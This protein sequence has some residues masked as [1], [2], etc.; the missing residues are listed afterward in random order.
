MNTFCPFING[1]CR[2]DCVFRIHET[3]ADEE[4]ITVCRL[5]SSC[6]TNSALCD[7]LIRKQDLEN[8]Q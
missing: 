3:T 6:G 8:E 4:T 2:D 7:L 5:V 1:N